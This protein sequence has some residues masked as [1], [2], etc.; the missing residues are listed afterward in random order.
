MFFPISLLPVFLILL[1]RLF[2]VKDT[3]LRLPGT[4]TAAVFFRRD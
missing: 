2:S 3:G 1:Q 4:V